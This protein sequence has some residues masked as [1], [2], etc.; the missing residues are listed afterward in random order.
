M[1]VR[2][3]RTARFHDSEQF[4]EHKNTVLFL[5]LIVKAY[6][7][8]LEGTSSTTYSGSQVTAEV[9]VYF[10]SVLYVQR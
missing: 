3:A 9:D 1:E 5:L 8:A 7:C 10:L 6:M 2:L 4:I